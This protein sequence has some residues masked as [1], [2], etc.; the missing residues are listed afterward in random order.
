MYTQCKVKGLAFE[1]GQPPQAFT[2]SPWLI[3]RP[4]WWGKY[5]PERWYQLHL[6]TQSPS[7]SI[8]PLTL[9]L[10]F[11]LPVPLDSNQHF[12]TIDNSFDSPCL[13]PFVFLRPEYQTRHFSPGPLLRQLEGRAGP[14]AHGYI[15]PPGSEWW[16]LER[17]RNHA[18]RPFFPHLT[19]TSWL[20]QIFA[21]GMRDLFGE[22]GSTSDDSYKPLIVQM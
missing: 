14:S 18:R 22:F 5:L 7:Q 20:F 19:F 10:S 6:Q 1:V 21:S 3:Y 2:E 8:S 16:A 13:T 4:L 17:N 9:I 12:C 11:F 15:S